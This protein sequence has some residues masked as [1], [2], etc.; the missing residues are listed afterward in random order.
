M[1]SLDLTY[2]LIYLAF[3]SVTLAFLVNR[4]RNGHL[5]IFDTLIWVNITFL[6]L[7]VFKTL[8]VI[9]RGAKHLDLTT[10]S[11]V[12]AM[13]L[14]LVYAILWIAICGASYY[15]RTARVLARRLPS[16][17]PIG[18]RKARS[19]SV[20]LFTFGLIAWGVK[21][22]MIGGLDELF[23]RP[24]VALLGSYPLNLAG[25]F[26][27]L[28]FQLSLCAALRYRDK[29]LGGIALVTGHSEKVADKFVESIPDVRSGWQFFP[30]GYAQPVSALPNKQPRLPVVV[31]NVVP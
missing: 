30:S 8:S 1:N 5:D 13:N 17:P 10:E 6:F 31:T 9:T 29:V 3:L 15:S 19:W 25:T 22:N 18:K 24:N 27:S 21:I 11:D 23:Y 16:L 4:A 26:V 7:F 28:G 2:L 12:G 14:A 20:L